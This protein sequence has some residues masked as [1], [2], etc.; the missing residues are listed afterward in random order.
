MFWGIGKLTKTTIALVFISKW[1][2]NVADSVLTITESPLVTTLAPSTMA[3]QLQRPS[4]S[5]PDQSALAFVSLH[6]K[7]RMS[8]AVAAVNA[9]WTSCPAAQHN[10][11]RIL[12]VFQFVPMVAVSVTLMISPTSNIPTAS[13]LL[14][15]PCRMTALQKDQGSANSVHTTTS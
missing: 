10:G 15:A 7:A 6:K 11:H 3:V 1:T 12:I 4:L 8:C 2:E 14:S 13:D 9:N 5:S